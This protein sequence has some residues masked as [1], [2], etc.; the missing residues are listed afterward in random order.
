MKIK[1]TTQCSLKFATQEKKDK[2]LGLL[3]EY[4]KLVNFFINEFWEKTP[5]KKELLK[6]IV[7]LPETTLGFALRQIAARNAIEMVEISKQRWRKKAIKPTHKGNLLP[8]TSNIA[9]LKLSTASTEFDAWLQIRGGAQLDLPI[10][11][12]KH[13]NNLAKI[14]KCCNSM[15]ITDKDV[16]L[17]FEIETGPKKEAGY[18]LGLDSGINALASLSNG[19]QCGFNVKS[20]IQKINRKQNGSNAQK[21]ARKHLQQYMCEEAEAIASQPELKLLV[22]EKLKNL[23]QKTKQRLGKVSRKLVGSWIYRYWL[24]RVQQQCEWNR[25]S[26]RTVPA[27]NTSIYC[28]ACGCTSKENRLGE[29]FR[30]QE[31]GYAG[32]ADIIAARNILDRFL[33][34]P[35]G[36]GFKGCAQLS[37]T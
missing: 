14:G 5:S 13:Y 37:S 18:V 11:F 2:L 24:N 28:P 30:C 1:R 33:S 17:F 32:N 34:G 10:K 4:S 12:H 22:V 29:M 19:T 27:Y 36:A 35:Y 21:R 31:C 8:S 16:K 6:P 15:L 7:D 23:H 9:K 20:I 3:D 25:V 26:F